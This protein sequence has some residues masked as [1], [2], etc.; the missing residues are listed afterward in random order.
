MWPGCCFK[1]T[2]KN[3]THGMPNIFL[4]G[5]HC[6][7]LCKRGS[8]TKRITILDEQKQ[9]P[10]PLSV[11]LFPLH[12]SRQVSLVNDC[13]CTKVVSSP[14]SQDAKN[15]GNVLHFCMS[16]SISP[17]QWW[18]WTVWALGLTGGS[19]WSRKWLASLGLQLY[20]TIGCKSCM[21]LQWGLQLSHNKEN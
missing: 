5:F 12:S 6:S 16:E 4:L 17:V 15:D 2:V 11:V 19:K 9:E 20:H 3:Q 1:I 7:L 10:A 14:Y 8:L 21:L 18:R 13:A